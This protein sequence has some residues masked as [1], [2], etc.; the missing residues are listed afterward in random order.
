MHSYY[1]FL[2]NGGEVKGGTGPPYL[3]LK[4]ATASVAVP[5]MQ[6]SI[7]NMTTI[8]GSEVHNV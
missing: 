6:A 5:S 2:K 4:S 7:L 8:T 3:P 1:V